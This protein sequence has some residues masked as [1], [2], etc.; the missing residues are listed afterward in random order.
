MDSGVRL[1][2]RVDKVWRGVRLPESRAFWI[3]AAAAVVLS[4]VAIV[5]S[6]MFWDWLSGS[7][8]GS[9]TIRNIGLVVAGLVALPLAIW[10][11]IVADRQASAARRQAETA[12]EQAETAQQ[13]LLNERYQQGAEMLGSPVLS[14]RLGGIY[15]L[16]RLASEHP[17]QYHVQI[18]KLLC[19]LVR[20]PTVDSDYEDSNVTAREDVQ[21]VIDFIRL[22]SEEQ[23][24]AEVDQKLR[25]NLMRGRLAGV[26]I[27]DANLSGALLLE[28]DLRRAEIANADLSASLLRNS[29]MIGARLWNV[30]FTDAAAGSMDLSGAQI[31]QRGKT[32]FDL[33]YSKL[34]AANLHDLDLSDKIFQ[35]AKLDFVHFTACDLSNTYFLYSNLSRA[36]IIKSTLH[37]AS[38]IGTNMTGAILRGT[39]ISG[40]CFYDPQGGAA[41]NPVTGLTQAQ[42]DEACADPNDPPDLDG[43]QDAETGKQLVWRGKPCEG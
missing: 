32:L 22:R 34:S 30:D 17:Q 27:S 40:V 6:V 35:S 7:E 11:G 31:H 39:D 37:G 41:K 2:E 9:T 4:S 14:V 13:S 16:E 33:N 36:Q 5:L 23:V 20:D 8:S 10:R 1:R 28:A 18:M 3:A 15:A 29:N 21:A 24:E 38:I 12:L 26:E 42:L 19:A 43:V 25:L